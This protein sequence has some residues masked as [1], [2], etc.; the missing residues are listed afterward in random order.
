MN[1]HICIHGHFYQSPME[2]PWLEEIELQDSAYPYHDWNQ[3]ITAECYAPNTASRILDPERRIIDIVNNYS[4]IS[5]SFGPT[6]LIWLERNKPDIYGAILEADHISREHFSGHGSA[7][8]QCYNHMIMPL[9][10]ARDK[11]TQIIWGLRDFEQRFGRKP[12]GMWLPEMAVD[13]ESLDIMAE[14]GIR[15]T[16]LAPCQARQ[17]RK[18]RGQQWHDVREGRIDPKLPYQCRLP[19]GRSIALFF[20]D[21]PISR[22]IAFQDV[23]DNGENFARRLLSGFSD[24]PHHQLLHIATEGEIYGHHHKLGDMALA[25]CLYYLE[26]NNLAKI[27]VYGEYLETHPPEHEV[28]IFEHTSWSCV[29]GV[30]RW[31]N[32]CGCHTGA[33][34]EWDQNWR[35]ALR[36]AM[37]WLRDNLIR[38]YEDRISQYVEDPWQARDD[39]ISVI[40][41]RSREN[42]K[43]FFSKH[44][45]A[46]FSVEEKIII[47]KHLE[48][49]RHAMLMYTSC[50]WFFDDISGPESVQV[51]QFAARAMQLAEEVSSLSLEDTYISLLERAS[52]NVP[53]YQ[54][55][56]RVY[57]ELVKPVILD[58]LRVGV[59]YAISSLFDE[60]SAT[61]HIYCYT[62]NNKIYEREEAGKQ[63]LALG[64]TD[65]HS[66]ITWEEKVISFVILHLGDH[67]FLGGVREYMGEDA[68]VEMRQG[69]EDAFL[70]SD[71]S[72]VLRLVEQYFDTGDCSLW[73]LFKDEQRKVL[74]QILDET[75]KEVEGSL[76]QINEH[77]YSIIQ[78]MR[79]LRVPLPRTLA[80]IEELMLNTGLFDLLEG[81]K[82]DI[83]GLQK[84]IE[85]IRE[86]AFN[87][88]RTTL[89]FLVSNKVN[90]MM[91][92]FASHP[93][94][95][96]LLEAAESLLWSL[97]PLSLKLD[98]WEAQNIYFSIG[99]QL[100]SEMK[101]RADAGDEKAGKWM[102][103]FMDFGDHLKVRII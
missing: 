14:Q 102:A 23:L 46:E 31:R 67:N 73:H 93:Q 4:R 28:E 89:N 85:K 87:V 15:F 57:E 53:E 52:G 66:E 20:Y 11:R 84:L 17:V 95:S 72:G 45:V 44:A 49:Q 81:K 8:A 62:V 92:K 27:T 64:K 41:D 91:G 59:H 2:N 103:R 25:Y 90:A 68:F 18:M 36:G 61:K 24:R 97:Q 43:G 70:R 60:Y 40:L 86:G 83:P 32:N 79:Q 30:E 16:V 63:K 54:N 78:V 51:M 75:L 98:L 42:A 100:F 9:A 77:H 35:S 80:L 71:I 56:A 74:N 37:D 33:P 19:S 101:E 34:S 6:L 88:D 26:K 65:I 48:M 10:N 82:I 76:R 99:K 96:S 38:I 29:H 58:L 47:L 94:D 5:F 7:M 22:D 55:G 39:Y 3:R 50:G 13:L 69:I 1:R 21:G 12:E